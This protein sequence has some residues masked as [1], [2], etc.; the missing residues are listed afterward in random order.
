MTTADPTPETP[1]V[2]D[3]TVLVQMAKSDQLKDRINRVGQALGYGYD[4]TTDRLAQVCNV[5]TWETAWKSAAATMPTLDS[6]TLSDALGANVGV[7]TDAMIAAS[8]TAIAA[9]V[10]AAAAEGSGQAS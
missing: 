3:S 8:I 7:I 4:I 10:A 6:Q 9:S 2:I 5:P 1:T